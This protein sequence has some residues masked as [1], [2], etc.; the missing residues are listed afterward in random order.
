MSMKVWTRGGC[1]ELGIRMNHMCLDF[2][3]YYLTTLP[4]IL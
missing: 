3:S 4:L 1:Y 2:G